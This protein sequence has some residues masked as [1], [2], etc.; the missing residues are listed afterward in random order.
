MTERLGRKR[1]RNAICGLIDLSVDLEERCQPKALAHSQFKR[2]LE[3]YEIP[4]SSK[5]LLF[6]D[7]ND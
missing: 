2:D 7:N 3:L 4:S 1:I 6:C 5:G